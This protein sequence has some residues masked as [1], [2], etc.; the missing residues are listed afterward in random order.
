MP[1]RVEIVD[2]NPALADGMERVNADPQGE[3]WLFRLANLDG[4]QYSALLDET[5]Y[6]RLLG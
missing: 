4:E 2:V 5:A 1:L 3:G 6:Q